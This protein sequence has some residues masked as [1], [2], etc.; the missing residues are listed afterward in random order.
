MGFILGLIIGAVGWEFFGD[1][2]KNFIRE[3]L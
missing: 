1:K 2:I 3:K